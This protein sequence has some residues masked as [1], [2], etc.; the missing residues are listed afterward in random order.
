M[1]FETAIQS[2]SS[3]CSLKN[4]GKAFFLLLSQMYL[5]LV[6]M[7]SEMEKRGLIKSSSAKKAFSC[8]RYAMYTA[9]ETNHTV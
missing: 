7:F 9:V 5:C 3:T 6:G 2:E 1:A 4:L 8:G